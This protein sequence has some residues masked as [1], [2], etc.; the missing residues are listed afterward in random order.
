MK[1]RNIKSLII[2][3]LIGVLVCFSITVTI[4]AIAIYLDPGTLLTNKPKTFGDIKVWSQQPVIPEGIEIPNGFYKDVHKMLWM[5][6]NDV[7]FLMITQNEAGK[8]SGLCLLRSKDKPVLTMNPLSSPGKWGQA[9]YCKSGG[10]GHPLGDA[11]VDID[12]DG[13]FDLKI[14]LDDGGNLIS[15]FILIDGSWQQIDNVN[16]KVGRAMKGQTSYVFEP[17]FGWRRE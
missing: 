11:F 3:F 4:G 13:S 7:P 5:T 10:I 8:I 15:R 14:N 12:F 6:K 9:T 1:D 17:E 16:T 2:S